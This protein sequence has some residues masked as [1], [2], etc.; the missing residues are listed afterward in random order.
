[1]VVCE[2]RIAAVS[3]H[4][5]NDEAHHVSERRDT[6]VRRARKLRLKGEVKKALIALREACL[7]DERAAWLWALYGALLGHAGRQDDARKALRHALW[8]RRSAGDTPR[9]RSTQRLLD[10]L[11][12][13]SAAA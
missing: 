5:Q 4:T 12:V 9:V 13:P 8:L 6:L 3:R 2:G 11:G 7:M 10:E 1:M